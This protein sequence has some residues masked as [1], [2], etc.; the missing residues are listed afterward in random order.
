MYGEILPGLYFEEAV[1]MTSTWPGLFSVSA[2]HP[3]VSI[4]DGPM[5]DL[6]RKEQHVR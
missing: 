4:E 6:Y 1:R 5:K 2:R 3:E